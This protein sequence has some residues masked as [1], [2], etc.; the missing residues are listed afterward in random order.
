MRGSNVLYLLDND[1]LARLQISGSV[2]SERSDYCFRGLV[3]LQASLFCS[4]SLRGLK[5]SYQ[6]HRHLGMDL[7][8]SLESPTVTL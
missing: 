4:I 2:I 5:E 6:E 8:K 7:Y 1:S 3:G